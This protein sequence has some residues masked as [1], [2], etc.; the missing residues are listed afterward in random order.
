[1]SYKIKPFNIF[2]NENVINDRNIIIEK[3]KI[4]LFSNDVL[5]AESGFSISKKDKWFGEKYVIIYNLKTFEQFTGR[6]HAKYLLEKIFDYV[7]NELNLKIITLIVD[8]D[9]Y[10]AS[11]LYFNVGFEIFIEYDDSY[12]LVKRI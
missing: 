12:S 2:T 4:K 6:G 9:N 11:N 5:V 3:N 1:M 7:K 10:K 8:K